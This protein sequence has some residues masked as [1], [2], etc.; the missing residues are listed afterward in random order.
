[1]K[2]TIFILIFS[3]TLTLLITPLV[4]S[5]SKNETI[6]E[7]NLHKKSELS[8]ITLNNL[9]HI[10]FFNEKGISEKIMTEDQFL[11]YTLLFKSFFISHSQYNDLLVQFDSKETVNK[12]KGKQVDLY[13][14]YYGFQ[15]SGGKPNKTACMYG[16]VTL[17][18]NN[19]LYDTK[20]IPI[21]L[22]ID[23]IRTVVPLDI[24]K[25]NKKKVTIQELDLQ[26]RYYLHKQYNLYNPS[27]FDGKIQKGLIVFHTSKEPLV[28]YDLFNV[29]GQY[30][31]KLLKIYQDNKIIESENMHID[32]YLYTSLIV[33]ISLPLVL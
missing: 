30:P 10:H 14:S 24:V 2:K 13:G 23:S 31:D 20:K 27:T 18:E 3:L 16:G 22:W 19:Q 1:M 5:D 21:N 7:K 8:S 33:L 26:A 12:F 9:R 32:I 4:Y 28:S 11:D 25:T 29:I 15:C 17:H 6:K